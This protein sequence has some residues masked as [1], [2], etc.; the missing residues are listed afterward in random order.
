MNFGLITIVIAIVFLFLV[1][2]VVDCVRNNETNNY[3]N[4]ICS[5][6]S[7]WLLLQ[8]IQIKFRFQNF[9]NDQIL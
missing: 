4:K 7:I 5:A 6:L 3:D 9:T 8:L 1:R 2:C